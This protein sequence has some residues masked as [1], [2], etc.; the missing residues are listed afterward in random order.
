MIASV[1]DATI[2][3]SGGHKEQRIN[4]LRGLDILS[5]FN[6]NATSLIPRSLNNNDP[7]PNRVRA[8]IDMGFED[9]RA[10]RVLL[11]FRNDLDLA[12]D[13]LIHTP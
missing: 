8:L 3:L 6:I 10:R 11:H 1:T 7:D 2:V 12:M 5:V 4:P 13:Y 9:E